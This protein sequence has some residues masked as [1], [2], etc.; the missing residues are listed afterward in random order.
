[1]NS[2]LT[3]ALLFS[4]A[5]KERMGKKMSGYRKRKHIVF[6]SLLCLFA[7]GAVVSIER[8]HCQAS[9][10]TDAELNAVMG[11]VNCTMWK[12]RVACV[13]DPKT[14]PMGLDKPCCEI[15]MV[16]EHNGYFRC[17]DGGGEQIVYS[18]C[19]VGV[20]CNSQA[21]LDDE[22]CAVQKNCI[23]P[24]GDAQN[25]SDSTYKRGLCNGGS[26]EIV[27]NSCYY[28]FTDEAHCGGSPVYTSANEACTKAN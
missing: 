7:A 9:T 15:I 11:G 27:G 4:L 18:S 28:I 14:V 20:E 12:H 24:L 6:L 16:D 19:P 21:V 1:M 23:G 3:G 25:C 5:T 2:I 26:C 8:A 17:K 22:G 10:V 13:P